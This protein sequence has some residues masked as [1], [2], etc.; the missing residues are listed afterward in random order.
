[1]NESGNKNPSR[2]ITREEFNE[3]LERGNLNFSGTSQI[4]SGEFSG[5]ISVRFVHIVTGRRYW[6]TLFNAKHVFWDTD[7]VLNPR[8]S[9]EEQ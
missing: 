5:M 9:K 7:P 4:H 3:I 8:L 2:K 6:F 1:M